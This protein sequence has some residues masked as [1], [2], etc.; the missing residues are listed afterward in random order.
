M[1][2]LPIEIIEIIFMF[3]NPK[4]YTNFVLSYDVA[5]CFW[6]NKKIRE[7]YKEQYFRVVREDFTDNPE[8]HVI[9]TVRVDNGKKHGKYVEYYK[10]GQIFVDTTYR[11]IR[12]ISR[13]HGKCIS[14]YENGQ[15][16]EDATYQI[17]C[18]VS[19]KHGKYTSYFENGQI[20]E[21]TTYQNSQIHGKY[22]R[23]HQNGQLYINA[24]YQNG[25][26]CGKYAEYYENGQTQ[27]EIT[28]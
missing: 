17:I 18:D 8:T 13:I 22:I 14:Y 24:T 21:D 4:D 5:L 9:K 2:S 11:N 6:K 23:Y 15:I 28:Y 25:E 12:D 19:Q 1:D 10:N 27:T 7:R 3:I 20:W 26:R 16:Y